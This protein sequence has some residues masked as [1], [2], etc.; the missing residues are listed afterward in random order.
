MKI[1]AV[2]V[3]YRPGGAVLA[4]DIPV[5]EMRQANKV[6]DGVKPG[7]EYD[8]TVKKHRK[9]RSISANGYLWVLIRKIAE[10]LNK[11]EIEV[12]REEIS[13]GTAYFKLELEESAV[14]DFIRTWG[15]RGVGWIAVLDGSA[16][17]LHG[18]IVPGRLVYRAYYGSSEY[19]SKQMADLLDRVI[20]DAR[21]LDIET[22]TPREIAV[23]KSMWKGV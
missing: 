19:D 16:V 17:D 3:D 22:M 6:I 4:F 18:N 12:Y 9:R 8:I 10:K 20:Q 23:L 5:S 21:A 11:P 7:G 15:A 14:N 13:H 1:D 2:H